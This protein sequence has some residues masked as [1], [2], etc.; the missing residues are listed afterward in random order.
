MEWTPPVRTEGDQR[1]PGRRSAGLVLAS[2]DPLCV[3]PFETS[4]CRALGAVG[5]LLMRRVEFS[6][7]TWMRLGFATIVPIDLPRPTNSVI[8]LL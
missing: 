7:G 4:E 8:V 3:H 1:T 2:R 6:P 5:R